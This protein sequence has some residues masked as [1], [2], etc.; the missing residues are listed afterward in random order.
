MTKEEDC[1]DCG[2]LSQTTFKHRVNG[3][4]IYYCNNLKHKGKMEKTVDDFEK[5]CDFFDK[6]KWLEKNALYN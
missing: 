2:W 1:K 5:E 3:K 4:S 6:I